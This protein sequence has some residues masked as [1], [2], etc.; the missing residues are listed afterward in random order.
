MLTYLNKSLMD[1]LKG[2]PWLS[3][4]T[5]LGSPGSKKRVLCV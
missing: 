4:S 3:F 1:G 5:F 2:S